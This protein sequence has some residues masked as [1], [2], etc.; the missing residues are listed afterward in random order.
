MSDTAEK[1]LVLL[2]D[3]SVDVHRLLQVRLRHEQIRLVGV[4]KASEGLEA[5]K[6]ERPA[7]ILLDLD[8]PGTDGFEMLRRLKDDSTLNNVPVIVLSALSSSEDKV[9]AFDLGATDYVTK[10]FDLAE[11]R[12]RLRAALR[13]DS[14]LHLLAERADVDGLTGLGNRAHFNKRWAEK[15]AECKRYPNPLSLAMMDIDFFKRINDTYGHPAGDEVLQGVSKLLQKECRTPDV[16]CRFGGEEFALVMPSTGPKDAMVVAERIREALMR[17]VWPRHSEHPITISIGVVG[18]ESTMGDTTPEKWLELA[19]KNLYT[20]KHSGR[21]K[22]VTTDLMSGQRVGP[23]DAQPASA[24]A[25][26]G[27]EAAAAKAPAPLA[28]AA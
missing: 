17:V 6:K 23:A 22:V 24:P 20:A 10:P 4:E 26:T 28:K 2:V 27:A 14:L 16:P 12:A 15:V 7:A 8:M 25:I 11:L 19:D 9:T 13:L 18:T 21:N 3:D 5:A 1:P